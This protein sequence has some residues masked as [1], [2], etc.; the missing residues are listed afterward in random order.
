MGKGREW[1]VP[2]TGVLF[3]V[4]LIISF[5][6]VG[7]EPPTVSDSTAR[8][9]V[10]F[11]GD[12]EGAV[13]ASAAIATVGAAAFIFFFGYVR[14]VLRA[15]EGE[16]GMLSMVAFAGAV[17]FATGVAIDS[18]ISFALADAADD[19]DPAAVQALVALFQ[20]DFVPLA[21]GLQVL[22]LATGI[23]V[24]R[25]GALPKWLGWIAILL[26]VIAVTPAGFV[27]FLGAGVWVLIVSVVLSLRARKALP[28]G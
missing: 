23:S 2:L 4:L 15:T 14:K 1:L 25:H 7:E 26:A 8:E 18:T 12:N 24:V 11:Y 9:L 17:V 28:A 20:N 27:A 21:L 22:L 19:I 6:V 10:E 3:V 13:I 16:G 5:V